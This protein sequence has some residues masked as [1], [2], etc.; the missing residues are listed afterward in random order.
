MDAEETM[1]FAENWTTH[2]KM[3]QNVQGMGCQPLTENGYGVDIVA[4][5][6]DTGCD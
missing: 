5:R 2:V 4:T 6:Y 1:L 3:T